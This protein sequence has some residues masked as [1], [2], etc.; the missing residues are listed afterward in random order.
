MLETAY[1]N[2]NKLDSDSAPDGA[3][4]PMNQAWDQSHE[5]KWYIELQRPGGDLID[6]GVATNNTDAI[7]RGLKIIRWGFDQQQSD[8][9]FDCDDA[10][11]STSFFVESTAHALLLMHDAGYDSQFQSDVDWIKPRLLAAAEWME[12]P[13]IETVGKEHNAPYTHR[14]YLVGDAFGET[15]VLLDDPALIRHS[16]GYIEDGLSLQ[17]PKGYNPE[18]GGYDVSYN[19]VGL[20]YAERYYSEVAHGALKS[21]L[22]AMLSKGV[23]WEA[24]RINPDG[25]VMTEGDSRVGGDDPERDRTGATKV[26][27][28][29]QVFRALDYWSLISGQPQYEQIAE[30]VA[31]S[32]HMI[33]RK[34]AS[35]SIKRDDSPRTT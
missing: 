30:K 3:Y 11:H 31:S 8:G 16:E 23:A 29:G 6:G 14:R 19:A 32:A 2:V 7:A 34:S 25:S 13:D 27:A 1:R 15:G 22:Y 5:G 9:G 28:F 20:W 12:R 21:R 10:F 4:G 17:T 35:I 33:S 24:S 26:V 18:K